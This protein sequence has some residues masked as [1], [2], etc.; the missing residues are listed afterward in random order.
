MF[1][2]KVR[3]NVV[4][5]HKVA[6]MTGRK[7][8][9]V[10]PL[11]VDE[12]GEKLLSTGRSF[13]AVDSVDAGAGDTVLITQGSSAR[14]TP[15]TK[16]LPIDTVIALTKHLH[17]LENAG[18][19]VGSQRNKALE[20]RLAVLESDRELLGETKKVTLK[21]RGS[22]ATGNISIHECIEDDPCLGYPKWEAGGFGMY[23]A[24]VCKAAKAI[25]AGQ[26]TVIPQRLTKANQIMVTKAT[27]LG[28]ATD[29][30]GGFL[31]APEHRNELLKKTHDTG[32]VFPR[33]RQV[34]MGSPIVKIPTIN[35]TS[36]AD[37]S[38]HG[39]VRAFRLAEGA[40]LT[41]SKPSFG[42]V[43]LTATKVA[44]LG[45][46]T[47][48]LIEDSPITLQLFGELFAEELAFEADDSAI[49]GTGSGSPL[50]VLK[51]NCLVS[52]AK[53]NGQSAVTIEYENVLKMWSRMWASSRGN[54][55]WFINQDTEPQLNS[56]T[57]VVGT[58]GVPVYLPA[59]GVSGSPFA[60]LFGRPVIP[61]EQC[62]T[63]G[64]VG[65]IIFAD[66]SQYLWGT[67]G[68]MNTASSIHVQFTT[69]EEA[70]RTTWRN[71]GQPW[72]NSALT[73]FTGSSNTLSPFVAL[74]TRA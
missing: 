24:D 55:A 61:I 12:P 74:A 59:G 45:Y 47:S 6:K 33:A 35:E 10:D 51:A 34:P 5:T 22:A 64:T 44:A 62:A 49:N 30:E 26:H 56:M 14:M 52:V 31:V 50:G 71:D 40:T 63:L 28:E 17:K 8:L 27:G 43:T 16:N 73:P 20:D 42:R 13:V 23:C 18:S 68:G 67:R 38:R 66:M 48:E 32:K 15:Q 21:A 1:I 53:E 9:I 57:L 60:T 25:A 39:G 54:A 2:A 69:D 4:A 58:G 11:V 65:D 7:L 29:D 37:G 46:V 19:M 72:W 36:R 70:F 3:G 41:A